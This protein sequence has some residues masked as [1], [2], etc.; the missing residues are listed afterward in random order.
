MTKHLSDIEVRGSVTSTQTVEGQGGVITRTVAGTPVDTV[1]DGMIAI[2]TT[3]NKLYYRSGGS[4]RESGSASSVATL[5]DVEL[6]ALTAGQ[7]LVYN[8]TKWVNQSVA[9]G[10]G[11]VY[12]ATIGDGTTSTFTITHNLGTRDV[13]VVVRNALSPYE[14]IQVYWTATTASAVTLDFGM[15][16]ASN[17]VRV[18]VYASVDGTTVSIPLDGLTDTT[19]TSPEEFQSLVYNGTEWV[20]Q[21]A[22][23][24]TYVRNAETTT[25]TTGTVVYL[26]GATGDHA[27]VKRADNDT[28]ATSSKTI[29]LVAAPIAASQNGPVV[30]R[31]YVDGINLSAYTAGQVLWL[32][33]NGTF[34]TTKP[35][36]PKHLVFV[37]VV[38]RAT[39]NGIVYV[40]TQN[41]Y[42]LDELHD[43]S[44]SSP[45]AGQTIRYNGSLWVNSTLS[46]DDIGNVSAPTPT[47][48][49][50]LKY[51]DGL[52]QWVP[53]NIPTINAL[54]DI[55]DVS[56]ASPTSGDFLKWNGTAWVNDQIDLA[57]D[58]TGNYVASLV[59][60]TG[61]TLANNTGEGATPTVSIGQA[62][63]T[64]SNV[65]F[66]DVN[67]SGNLTV[68]GTTTTVNS[69]TVSVDDKNLELGSVASPTNT[70][71]DGG[72]IT[73][74]GATD[75]T[76]NWVNATGSWTSSEDVDLASGKVLRIAGVQVLSATQYTGNAATATKWATARTIILSG[77]L[78]GSVSV[79]GSANATLTATVGSSSITNDK[80]ANSSITVGSTSISLGSSATTI[81]GLTLASPA[82]TT[83]ITSSSPTLDL[84]AS[85][86]TTINLGAMT[87]TIN[88]G[89]STSTTTFGGNI[90]ASGTGFTNRLL[91]R[92]GIGASPDSGV[93]FQI[94]NTGAANKILV[95][96]SAVSQIASLQEWQDST[97]LAQAYVD[98][99][100]SIFSYGTVTGS[101]VNG[102]TS[103]TGY[104]LYSNTDLTLRY[105][106]GGTPSS[107]ATISVARGTSPSV[108]IRWNETTDK[109]QFT[110]DGTTYKDLGSGGV[111]VS[112]TAPS[113]PATG[114]MWYES[115]TGALYAYYDSYWIE[116]GGSAAY[117]E[118]VG[119]V[120]AKGD[121]LAGTGSQ[122]ISRLG[123]GAN[124]RRLVADSTTATGL[125]WADD[126][127]NSV[128]TAKGDL[129]AATSS[130]AVGRR[131]VGTDGQVLTADSTATTGLAWSNPPTGFRNLVINGNFDIWQRNT[132]FTTDN[133]ATNIYTADRWAARALYPNSSA[134]HVVSQESSVVP[135]GSRY[136]LKSVI[137][138]AAVVNN[139][140]MQ[141]CYTMEAAEAV[142]YAGKTMTVSMRVRGIQNIDRVTISPSYNTSGGRSYDGTAIST[143]NF[144][145]TTSGYTTCTVTFT[146][147]ALATLTTSGTLGVVVTYTRSSGAIEQVGDG[148]YLSQVQLEQNSVATPFEQR[149]FQAELAL[150][151]RYYE[152][153][154]GVAVVPGTANTPGVVLAVAGNAASSTTGIMDGWVT[155]CVTK[156][157]G[158]SVTVY[159]P[160]GNINKCR[161]T[162]MG[163]ANN[164]NQSTQDISSD[165]NGFYFR[166]SSGADANTIGVHFTASAEL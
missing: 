88:I 34:T 137:G 4:W 147:P 60:G 89:S 68:N 21:Y 12:L 36:A 81:S 84:F 122:A 46:L 29:G 27:T 65:T 132:S 24:V 43:V 77:D 19:I 52:L 130:G 135:D 45:A 62:V 9:A 78:S 87:G 18:A 129:I 108:A 53:A 79:D 142:K 117:N 163:V 128:V 57:T 110:N 105:G 126:S 155:F 35:S 8:G 64:T 156:R 74:K 72:G 49:Q 112:D 107:N 164:D 106:T 86:P 139:S 125:A 48:G 111:T 3:N 91:G 149:P 30:T 93:M 127:V 80:L 6:T 69:T 55:G 148:I 150:C 157:T 166:S 61:V 121:I 104:V 160:V 31:G 51:D 120:Q 10:S 14:V 119:S 118:I 101:N 133:A 76:F 26:F 109:W 96:K 134:V 136:A 66:N 154:Y 39:N 92:T 162:K 85:G 113:S 67:V 145:V 123:V 17:S 141:L 50:F 102:Y 7:A 95:V 103:T 41:G 116:I 71:A 152:K 56:A 75:K 140:R 158:A 98:A 144:A 44:I 143:T 90:V 73:L 54:D 23:T 115:D 159:D 28:D 5:T 42:E 100:G 59:A 58:T 47:H 114:D 16:P 83:S 138:T 1:S 63:G 151:Q 82:V 99:T 161:R 124:G 94:T 11:A 38:V 32:N 37:G 22:S 2:D 146:V 97:G 165:H 131:S 15:P 70:T 33:T 20:N 25:L 153:S 40:A 13:V